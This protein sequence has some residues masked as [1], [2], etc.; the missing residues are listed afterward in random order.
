MSDDPKILVIDDEEVV[1]ASLRK[2][3]RRKGF[4]PEMV[5]SAQEGLE[6]LAARPFDLV[7]TDLMMPEMNGIEATRAI[8][9]ANPKARILMLSSFSDEKTLFPALEAGAAGFILKDISPDDLADAIRDT[10]RGKTR[11]H[12]RIAEMLLNRVRD[13]D[14]EKTGEASLADNLTEREFEVLK[15]ICKGQSNKEIADTMSISPM[16]V[17]THVSNLLSKLDLMDRTQAAI[18][19][20]RNGLV[21]EE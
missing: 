21:P 11:L 4:E 8:V 16:T 17:K 10:A 19:A 7:I 14:T 2:V 5:F 18:Y 3:L 6:L 13:G 12:P 1:H 15:L 9:T 20:I